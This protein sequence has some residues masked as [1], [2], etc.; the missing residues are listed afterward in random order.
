MTP[1]N[2]GANE[3]TQTLR[4]RLAEAE[5]MLRAIRQGEVDALVVE[6]TDGN[7]VYTLRGADEPYRNLIEQMQEGAVV[8]TKRGEILYSNSLFASLVGEA[9]ECVIGTP[10]G[11]FV[12]PTDRID[13]DALLSAGGGRRRI[14]LIASDSRDIEVS[15]SAT[16]TAGST[17][18]ERLNLVVTDL[19]ELLEAN[20]DRDRAEADGR[21]KDRFLAMLAHELR[22]PLGAIT[23]AL[24]VLE[25]SRAEGDVAPGPHEVI[26]RQV[27]HV[28]RLIDDLLDVERVVS[29]RTR[30]DRQPLDLAE[31]VR[32]AVDTVAGDGHIERT[33][34]ISTEPLWID[35]DAGR[36][37][38]VLTNLLTNAV[39][40]TSPSGRILVSLHADDNDAVLTVED[41][42]F[43]IS[44]ALLPSIFDLYVQ[45]DRTIGRA[46]GGLGI[47]LTLVRRLVEL[48][49][50][51]I[52][53]SSEGEGL[54]S[55]FTIR[56]RQI[57]S[58]EASE[59]G[60]A[61][62]DRRQ[63]GSRRVL[64]I[65]DSSDARE[66]LRMMLEL[67]GHEVFSAADGVRGLELLSTMKPD[68]GIIDINLPRMD[69]YQIA[70]RIREEAHGRSMLLLAMTGN[71]APDA[72]G[73]S[74][75]HGFDY[76][77]VKPVDPKELERLLNAGVVAL[78]AH[79]DSFR[80][81]SS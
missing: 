27:G 43:G 19:R 34:G 51:T 66:M 28:S 5:E 78:S 68:V 45:A 2:V 41:T 42:G 4:T 1:T 23:N 11:R 64:L 39:K 77:L 57:P 75:D 71:D 20:S 65:E 63:A 38:Q 60:S 72:A 15:V 70:R 58:P 16:T 7:Q 33:I 8:L 24:R 13:F 46:Q 26:A 52:E 49:G 73:H 61:S 47:G 22:N 32:R 12:H 21:A 74:S 10:I 44:A 59:G 30:L 3:D 69:G 36:I 54:G 76:H 62:E 9:L 67:A 56:L 40:Y 79:P 18:G 29:G 48:H 37:E 50:G 35:G 81:L 25:L 6:G 53:A 55:R 17:N 31:A 80:R 14:R